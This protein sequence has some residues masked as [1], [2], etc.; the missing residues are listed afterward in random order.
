[1]IQSTITG[2][3]VQLP[4]KPKDTIN[5]HLMQSLWLLLL[6]FYTMC[7]IDDNWIV[8]SSFVLSL[9]EAWKEVICSKEEIIILIN[10]AVWKITEK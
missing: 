9:F 3:K 2:L 4:G 6:H 7:E 10:Q 5:S 1:M 8:A